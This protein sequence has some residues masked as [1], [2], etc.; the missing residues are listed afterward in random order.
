MRVLD[1][2]KNGGEAKEFENSLN[3]VENGC[4]EHDDVKILVVHKEKRARCRRCK[5]I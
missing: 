1:K 5:N 2:D 3:K 4:M